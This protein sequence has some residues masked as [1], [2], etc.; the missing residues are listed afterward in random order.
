MRSHSSRPALTT[1]AYLS[2]NGYPAQLHDRSA[3]EHWSELRQ[4]LLI[5]TFLTNPDLH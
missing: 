2:L 1:Y 3:N 4:L 5:L